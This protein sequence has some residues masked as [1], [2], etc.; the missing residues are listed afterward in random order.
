MPGRG[1]GWEGTSRALEHKKLIPSPIST[2]GSVGSRENPGK[3]LTE[4]PPTPCV[5]QEASLTPWVL[6]K[7]GH[8]SLA[9]FKR[10]PKGHQPPLQ[11]LVPC[12]L[13]NHPHESLAQNPALQWST[14]IHVRQFQ[15]G[16][17]NL[18]LAGTAPC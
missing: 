14:Q 5:P 10:R 8:V 16:F 4:V 6:L 18:F 2:C 12:C 9:G 1:P 11:E 17:P 13:Q 7:I 15:G 3:T